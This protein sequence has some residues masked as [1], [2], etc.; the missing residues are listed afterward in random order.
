MKVSC[1]DSDGTS[2]NLIQSSTLVTPGSKLASQLG[3]TEDDMIL[4]TTFSNSS[5]PGSAE[6]ANHGAVCLF[7]FNKI[8]E[9]F[10]NNFRECY[11]GDGKVAQKFAKNDQEDCVA[12]SCFMHEELI[13]TI[14]ET[15]SKCY[16]S[17]DVTL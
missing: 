17:L 9:S 14:I 7:T 8:N 12:V 4:V 10:Y 16:Q 15:N 13:C 11:T 1:S 3:V 6:P 5:A 2:Y